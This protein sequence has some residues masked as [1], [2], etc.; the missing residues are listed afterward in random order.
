[1]KIKLAHNVSFFHEF[2]LSLLDLKKSLNLAIKYTKMRIQFK[3]LPNSKL[4]RPIHTYQAV[5]KRI[6]DGF[7]K[8]VC[9]SELNKALF[10]NKQIIPLAAPLLDINHHLMLECVIR[11]RECCGGFGYLQAAGH[12]GCIERLTLRASEA[13]IVEI[14]ENT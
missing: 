6:I 13:Q 14:P 8:L 5:G 4:E 9:F 3:T 12:A 11:L 10:N 7:C 2:N 1:M